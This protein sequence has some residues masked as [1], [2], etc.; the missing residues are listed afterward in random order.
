MDNLLGTIVRVTGASRVINA[1]TEL[2]GL[3]I[4]DV[5]QGKGKIKA[6]K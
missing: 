2:H 5:R 1:M 3:K 6:L 4:I